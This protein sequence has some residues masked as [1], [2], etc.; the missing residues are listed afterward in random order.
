[1]MRLSFQALAVFQR[2]VAQVQD[3]AGAARG[4]VMALHLE[5]APCR[6]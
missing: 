2:I 6:R 1:M 4:A 5:V 3:D